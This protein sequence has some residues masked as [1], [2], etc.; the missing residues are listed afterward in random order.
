MFFFSQVFTKAFSLISQFRYNGAMGRFVFL[1][2]DGVGMGDESEHNP[3]Y[4][5]RARHLPFFGKRQHLPDGT[6]VEAIDARLGVA[7]VP[8]SATGQA[9]LFSGRNAAAVCGQHRG[10]YPDPLLRRLIWEQNLLSAMA[11]SGLR[12]VYL[13]AYPFYAALFTSEHLRCLRSGK[14]WF[15]PAFPAVF[16]RRISVTTCMQLASGQRP[17]DEKDIAG[18]RALYQDYSNRALIQQGAALPEFSP[19][20]AAA[21]L[22]AAAQNV[23]LILY[24]YFQTDLCA[25]RRLPEEC[26]ALIGEL[27][28]LLAGLLSLLDPGCDTLLLTS[29]HGNLEDMRS[30]GHTLNPV[31]LLAWGKHGPLLRRRI[32]S[33]AD[34][35]PTILEAVPINNSRR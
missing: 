20:E 10:S 15:S 34:V 16:R 28:R 13:N 12:G 21:I 31:P 2:V 17:K 22:A 1:F 9:T 25:H 32:S 5:G 14:L 19:E 8:Q 11:Q 4:A 26:L 23:D 27:D 18:R 3:F 33:I 24:E 29:D 35:T 7:G 30:R 6:P